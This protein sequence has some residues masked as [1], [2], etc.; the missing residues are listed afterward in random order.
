[1]EFEKV[2]IMVFSLCMLAVAWFTIEA[3]EYID[4]VIG[5]S[6]LGLL[7][8]IGFIILQAPDVAITAAV[9]GSGITTAMFVLTMIKIN[10]TRARGGKR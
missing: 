1:M 6:L 4:N 5:G 10:K 7:S 8:V 2:M 3:Q 9:I